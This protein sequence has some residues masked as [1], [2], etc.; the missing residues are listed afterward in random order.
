MYM[1]IWGCVCT[2]V[3][4]GNQSDQL[5]DVSL[6]VFPMKQCQIIYRSIFEPFG[7]SNIIDDGMLCTVGDTGNKLKYVMYL[8]RSW[9]KTI[10]QMYM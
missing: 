1:S 4:S 8:C 3:F 6:R 9:V 2:Y 10:K 7:V 5:Q